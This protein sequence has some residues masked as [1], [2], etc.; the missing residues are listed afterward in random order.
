MSTVSPATGGMCVCTLKYHDVNYPRWLRTVKGFPNAVIMA[1]SNSINQQAKAITASMDFDYWLYALMTSNP[2]P[3]HYFTQLE[4]K[5]PP[6]TAINSLLLLP[7]RLLEQ[8]CPVDLKLSHNGLQGVLRV[9]LTDEVICI[10]PSG[11]FLI[12]EVF[13]HCIS[14]P[15]EYKESQEG[16]DIICQPERLT[17]K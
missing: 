4:R 10:L 15:E 2:L 5:N 8:I 11:A 6:F 13:Y 14:S 7:L 17:V 16:L 9:L 1:H 3:A 12:W